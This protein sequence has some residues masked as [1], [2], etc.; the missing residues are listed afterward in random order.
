[1]VNRPP[2]DSADDESTDD[3]APLWPGHRAHS[4]ADDEP[5]ADDVGAQA[6]SPGDHDLHD[7]GPHD[8]AS[9]DADG[10]QRSAPGGFSGFLRELPVLVV[11]ALVLAFLLRTF[12]VQV[13]YIP[14]SSMEPTLQ[15]DDRMVVEKVTY[16]F[17]EPR[18]GDIVV[19]EG[20][21]VAFGPQDN[22]GVSRVVRGA[23]QFLGLVPASARDYVKR[24]IGVGGDEVEITDG[25][26]W[27]NGFALEEPYVAFDDFD[28][29]GPVEVPDGHLFFLGDNR[30]NSSDSRRSLGFVRDDDVVGRAVVVLW[31]PGHAGSLTSVHHEL[32]VG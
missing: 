11:V 7:R 9:R 5:W 32:S 21:T 26:V 28:Q 19:F 31:P 30:P 2:H 18:R 3:P 8:A 24:V 25:T 10:P 27:V 15:I 14:S 13:F 12:V 16:R 22:G 6:G 29:F 17:R 20:P 4:G 1:V 23:G